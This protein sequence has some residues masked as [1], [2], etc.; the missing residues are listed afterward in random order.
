MCI[1]GG[2][3]RI[4][5]TSIESHRAAVR[6]AILDTTATLVAESGVTAASMSQIA[7]RAGIGRATLYK[8]FSDVETILIAW[9]EDRVAEHITQLTEL[10]AGTGQP[11]QRLE[12]VLIGYALIARRRTQHDG[13]DLSALVHHGAAVRR[14]EQQLA[15]LFS[16][17]LT[18]VARSGQLRGDVPPKELAQFCIHS[19]GA[20][21]SLGSEAAVRRLVDV[22]LTALRVFPLR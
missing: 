4:W 6:Q 8:Y 3:P 19:L 18:E 1:V 14:A 11:W 7:E 5:D 10:Q 16:G 13:G 17:L 22:T 12:A 20:A 15:D 2:V 9:H 21:G